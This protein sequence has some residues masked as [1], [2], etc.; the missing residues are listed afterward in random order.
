MPKPRDRKKSQQK[1]AGEAS[2]P[3]LELAKASVPSTAQ[4]KVRRRRVRTTAAARA[5]VP[6]RHADGIP[7]R[8]LVDAPKA[9]PAWRPGQPLVRRDYSRLPG[10][11]KERTFEEDARDILSHGVPTKLRA[12]VALRTG[13]S[14]DIAAVMSLRQAVIL[15][16]IHDAIE[17]GH[18]EK[19]D[20]ILD[21]TDPKSRR[22]E[23]RGSVGHLHA[24]AGQVLNMSEADASEVYRQ[25]TQGGGIIDAEIVSEGG[26]KAD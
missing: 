6:A 19:L 1:A 16:M 18:L 3:V 2:D 10:R 14:F 13:L 21:R 12:L 24:L 22:V 8:H 20:R 9:N 26:S 4:Q 5:L 17:K 25:M 11:P 15:L 23:H 7:L